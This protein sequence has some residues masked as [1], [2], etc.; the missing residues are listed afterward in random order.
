MK[1]HSRLIIAGLVFVGLLVWALTQERGRVPQEGEAFGIDAKTVSKLEIT[2]SDQK[3]V[4]EKQGEQWML[5]E[6]IQGYADKDA[7]ERMVR[8]IAELK[9][10]GTRDEIDGQRVDLKDAK[11]GLDKP[12]LTAVMT[13]EGRK[14]VTLHIGKEAP[15]GAEFFASIEGRDKL[16]MVPAS[17]RSDLTQKPEQ[18]RDKTVVHFED[19]K[20]KS[21]SLQYAD[22]TIAFEKRG[23][24][25]EAK[26][27]LTQPYEAKGDEWNCKQVVEKLSGLKAEAF[28]PDKPLPG[29]DPGF[30]K[31]TIK[32]T[33]TLKDGKQWVVNFGAKARLKVSDSSPTIVTDPKATGTEKDLVYVQLESRPE[34]LLCLDT[35]LSDL[36]KTDMDLRDKRIV[37]LKRDQVEELRVERKK[38]VSFTVRKSP[39]GWQLTAPT[40]GRAKTTTVDDILWDVNELEAREFLGQ[41]ENLQQYGLAI[42]DTTITLKVKGQSEPVKVLVGYA[43]G[44]DGHY[45]RTSQS[46]QVYVIGDALLL[47]LPKTIDDLKETSSTTTSPPS[48]PTVMPSKTPTKS[49]K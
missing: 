36:T 40:T 39:D 32:A 6:P 21:V 41:Q 2:G 37:E 8:A 20:V 4:L 24:G 11:F 47:D 10:S 17:L 42:P 15:G 7:T 13:Y 18:L 46:D 30:A 27:F 26:W 14:Q 35:I 33:I 9:P 12:Q 3:V 28:A 25:T 1:H 16:Y 23:E 48:G 45:A 34:T 22:K 43:K 19:D 38:G 49:T 44:E 29:Q 31:P 5:V